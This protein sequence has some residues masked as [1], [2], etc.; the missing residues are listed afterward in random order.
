MV[1]A[2]PPN[3][4]VMKRGHG[5]EIAARDGGL[6]KPST[7][8][9][10]KLAPVG[11]LQGQVLA[12]DRHVGFRENPARN[13]NTVIQDP[14]LHSQFG[15]VVAGEGIREDQERQVVIAHDE[16]IPR[17]GI[18][19]IFQLRGLGHGEIAGVQHPGVLPLQKALAARFGEEGERL[20][21]H[22]GERRRQERMEH[23][24]H[25]GRRVFLDAQDRAKL[26][27]GR[28]AIF[29]GFHTK[30]RAAGGEHFIQ[31]RP[32]KW[33]ALPLAID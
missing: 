19:S 12:R 11:G 9:P 33:H 30:D 25:R 17:K 10:R 22:Q 8:I 31:G 3:G 7:E 6:T 24:R 4:V 18:E 13:A 15:F 5:R 26:R 32:R 21:Q 20:R 27:V 28:G 16:L 2:R 14:L 29:D 1:A 23:A